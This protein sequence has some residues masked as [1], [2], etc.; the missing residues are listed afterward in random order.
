VNLRYG[1]DYNGDG[2]SSDRKP[3]VA[4]FSETARLHVVQPPADLRP[5]AR[6]GGAR[7]FIAEFFNLFNRVNYDVNR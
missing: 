5:A 1:Y 7:R 3:G 4:K 6:P 2:K